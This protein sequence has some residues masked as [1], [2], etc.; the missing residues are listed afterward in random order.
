MSGSGKSTMF[1]SLIAS[2]AIRYSPTE[3]RLYLI[4]GKYGVEFQPY[5]ELPHAEV[6]SLRTSP[7]L[8]RS[9]LAELVDE[10]ERRNALFARHNVTDLGSY[11]DIDGDQEKLPRLLLLVDEF[12]QLFEN[13][14]NTEGSTLL[15][16]LSQQGRSA[17]IHMLL[18]SQTLD[19]K[20]MY[21]RSDI[22]ANIHLRLAMQMA[23]DE[24]AGLQEFGPNGRKLISQTADRPGRITMNDNAGDDSS[25]IAGKVSLIT[26]E[27]RDEVVAKLAFRAGAIPPDELP[28]R[29]VFN[30]LAQPAFLDNPRVQ[31]LVALDQWSA[32]EA[33]E[34]MARRATKDGGLGVPDWLQG[35][36]PLALFLGQEFNVRGHA[37]AVLR[38]RPGNNIILVGERNME[39]VAMTA[40]LV[41]SAALGERPGD[42]RCVVADR[43]VLRT[44][45]ERALS[46]ASE[47]LANAGYDVRYSR[48]EA[49]IAGAIRD[50]DQ[51]LH[52][53]QALN[54]EDRLEEPTLL[55]VINEPDRV[56][57]LIR[58]PDD[59]G[60]IDSELGKTLR[61]IIDAGPS[62]GIHVVVGFATLRAARAVLEQRTIQEE[63]VHRIAMQMS[64]DDS[65]VFVRSAEASRLQQD[66]RPV[67]ALLFDSSREVGT[68]FKP[69]SLD[70]SVVQNVAEE[71]TELLDELA[72]VL[73]RLGTRQ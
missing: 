14:T 56:T 24:I 48:D 53:R 8:A 40:S 1:H 12:Q 69:Y 61:G 7:E 4:D 29:V 45:W 64:E 71:E 55:L 30:G 19:A 23:S 35:E 72:S 67:V 38:R 31:S 47:G 2:L 60:Y 68:K 10:M 27:A 73:E 66:D 50:V 58:Q 32:P 43:S 41:T 20:G 46:L 62:V 28:N 65:F 37:R 9:V 42:L 17:G 51:E 6:V 3:L 26:S 34:R 11:R 70:R 63:F 33:L 54:E 18:A 21:N 36:R 57:D 52:R 15:L 49:E 5:R 59:Y 44:G 13:D 25:N 39:R 16:K 22:F